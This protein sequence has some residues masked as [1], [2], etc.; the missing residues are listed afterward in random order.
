MNVTDLIKTPTVLHV[1][2]PATLESPAFTAT[3][4]LDHDRAQYYAASL[5]FEHMSVHLTSRCVSGIPVQKT[6]AP[7]L[8]TLITDANKDL[9][10]AHPLV[11]RWS[12]G[13]PQRAVRRSLIDQPDTPT[14]QAATLVHRLARLCGEASVKA[15]ARAA[16]I[17]REDARHW[18]RTARK[19]SIC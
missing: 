1:N 15:V 7:V 13:R 6:M 17:D 3:A 12:T 18:L 5:A 16:G 9:V 8:R 2:V 4:M 14:L 19:Q 10:L 11:R